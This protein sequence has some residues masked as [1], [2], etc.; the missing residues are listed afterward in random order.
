MLHFI[1]ES[2]N[3]N[4]GLNSI[5]DKGIILDLLK[6]DKVF[7]YF[8]YML[9]GVG[10]GVVHLICLQHNKRK[11]NFKH[12]FS[13][14]L[15]I[16]GS[17]FSTSKASVLP[18]MLSF[19]FIYGDRIK[20]INFILFVVLSIS[21]TIALITPMFND[22][23]Y[24]Q[25]SEI[26]LT[27]VLGNVDVLDYIDELNIKFGDYKNSSIFYIFWPFFQFFEQD[28]VIPGIWLHGMVYDNWQGFGPNPTFLVDLIIAPFG[29]GIVL[30]PFFGSLLKIANISSFRVLL[31][32]VIYLFLQDW[33]MAC[34]YFSYFIMLILVGR[35]IDRLRSSFAALVKL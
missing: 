11:W 17:F 20:I 4:I 5:N 23:D 14:F 6:N 32:N 28:F 26:A 19:I 1:L 16:A 29:L 2:T 27:R 8:N 12:I 24:H 22:L 9:G 30:A 35:Y 21:I 3:I 15:V 7:K 10:L 31:S 18:I 33:Y 34:I 25:V 13:I